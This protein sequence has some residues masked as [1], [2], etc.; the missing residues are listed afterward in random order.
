MKNLISKDHIYAELG[1]IVRKL[2]NGRMTNDKI[3]V[4]KSVGNAVQDIAAASLILENA[5]KLNIGQE[6]TL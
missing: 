4:F 5:A 2:K 1:E 3:T 6:I